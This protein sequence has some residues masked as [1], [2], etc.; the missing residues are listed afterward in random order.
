MLSFDIIGRFPGSDNPVRRTL[1]VYGEPFF[2][3]D[4]NP[5]L[6]TDEKPRPCTLELARAK[7][8]QWSALRKIGLDPAAEIERKRQAKIEKERAKQKS[9]V[10]AAFT[11]YFKHK[12]RLRSIVQIERDMRREFQHWLDRPLSDSRR[13]R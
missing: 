3:A 10:G 13:P 5:L 6:D 12:A 1:G 2:D 7:A 11:A 9:T 8:E 4:G